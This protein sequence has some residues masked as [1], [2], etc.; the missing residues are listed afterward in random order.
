MTT[1]NKLF[2][3]TDQDR[4]REIVGL[5]YTILCNKI[6]HGSI[7][8]F[9]EAS[10][11]L[12]FGIILHEIGKLFE[13]DPNDRFQI[14]FEVPISG[15]PCVKTKPSG[16][17]RCDIILQFNNCVC[18]IELKYLTEVQASTDHRWGVIKDIEL[19]ENYST[20]Q[21]KDILPRYSI[22]GATLDKYAK[23]TEMSSGIDISDGHTL[24]GKLVYNDT[25]TLKNTYDLKWDNIGDYYFWILEVP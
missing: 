2:F 15:V 19:L 22:I 10:F 5:S 9:N 6:A 18:A 25:I 13:S 12:Q 11:Q 16:N 23:G 7:N 17:A 4:V 3:M 21:R 8:V 1:N 20:Y 24:S 14:D